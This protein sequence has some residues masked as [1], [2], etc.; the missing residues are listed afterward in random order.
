MDGSDRINELTGRT[1]GSAI[2][3]HT[4]LGPGLLEH[5]YRRCLAFELRKE[6]LRVDEEVALDLRYDELLV[7][8]AYKIDLLVENILVVEIKAI[9]KITPVHHSQVLTYLKLGK[10][11]IG[12]LINFNALR[13]TDGLKRFVNTLV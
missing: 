12:L 1:I 2:R 11:S 10:K 5:T 13:L 7:L 9:E 6:G 3:I 4:R 8:G